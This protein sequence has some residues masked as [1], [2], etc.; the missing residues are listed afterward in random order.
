MREVVIG[1]QL[2]RQLQHARLLLFWRVEFRQ[3]GDEYFLKR[4]IAPQ[5]LLA[6]LGK[7][8]VGFAGDD[9]VGVAHDL[10]LLDLIT[11]LRPAEHDDHIR[12]HALQVRHDPRRLL[13]IPDVHANANDLRIV[14][15]DLLDDVAAPLADVEFEHGRPRPQ[16]RRQVRH[17]IAQPE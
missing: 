17:E 11:D 13:G 12:P 2:I 4:P 8:R 16:R 9:E 3:V 5:Q 14:R 7:R 15:E 6:Q 1:V 10:L